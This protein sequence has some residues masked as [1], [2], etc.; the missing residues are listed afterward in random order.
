M[1][2]QNAHTA[3]LT[4]AASIKQAREA[5][6]A[7]REGL[8]RYRVAFELGQLDLVFLNLVEPKV[9]EYEIKL[10]EQEQKMVFGVGAET[11]RA[12]PRSLRT[13]LSSR[14]RETSISQ[15]VR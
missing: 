9:T 10:I 8:K 14:G 5:L 13:S 7:A 4:N 2:L 12:W 11:S 3:L 1:E 15:R 6:M